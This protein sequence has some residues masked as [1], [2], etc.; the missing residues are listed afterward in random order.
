[1][2]GGRPK[3]DNP[4]NQDLNIRLTKDEAQRI[5]DCATALGKTRTDTIMQGIELVEEKIKKN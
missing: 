4:R 2:P 5:K 3:K 1:M